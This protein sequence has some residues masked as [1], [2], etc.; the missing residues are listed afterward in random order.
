MF[1]PTSKH[2]YRFNQETKNALSTNKCVPYL[3]SPIQVCSYLEMKL[4]QESLVCMYVTSPPSKGDL[5]NT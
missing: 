3:S 4:W 5:L 1:I 2:A